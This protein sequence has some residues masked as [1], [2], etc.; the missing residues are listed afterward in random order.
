MDFGWNPLAD[1]TFTYSDQNLINEIR[2]GKDPYV[3]QFFKLLALCHT[4]MVDKKDG[5]YY[6]SSS[7]CF[8]I[9]PKKRQVR[10]RGQVKTISDVLKMV[11]FKMAALSGSMPINLMYNNGDIH[12]KLIFAWFPTCTLYIPIMTS[13]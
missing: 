6:L 9:H 13:M 10:F 7:H 3:P 1:Y 12:L 8:V 2:F 4:V 5:K 11:A